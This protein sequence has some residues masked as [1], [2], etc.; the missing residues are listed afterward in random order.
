MKAFLDW[1]CISLTQCAERWNVEA[2][3]VKGLGERDSEVGRT[4]GEREAAKE[5]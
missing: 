4:G 3:V 5:F 2:A 1:T